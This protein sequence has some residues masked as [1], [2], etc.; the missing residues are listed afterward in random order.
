[1]RRL[2]D[3]HIVVTGASSGIGAEV[4]RLLGKAGARVTLA[5][6]NAERLAAVAGEV[7]SLG[8]Q[9]TCF[10]CD[11]TRRDEIF[12]LAGHAT[13]IF[14]QIDAWI[15]NAGGGI[16][17]RMLEATEEDMLA[18]YRLN[19][20]S[21]LWA[22]QA[23]VPSWIKRGWGQIVDVCSLAGKSGFAFGG[24][25]CA[26]KHAL[27][28]IGDTM[29]QELALMGLGPVPGWGSDPGKLKGIVVTTV[30]PGVT[31][32]DFSKNRVNRATTPE[33]Q[34][35]DAAITR[36]MKS[37]S[38][39]VRMTMGAH[40]TRSVARAIVRALF[41]PVFTL[42]THRGA[43]LVVLAGNLAP[44]LV[45]RTAAKLGRSGRA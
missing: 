29:R 13:N 4:C 24:G 31:V 9:A 34:A 26:S 33:Q 40:S 22:Y 35:E 30:Y 38:R 45:S 23:V 27:S 14:G 7:R 37:G 1:M 43:T 32:S 41:R 19:C 17:H 20:L 12:A 39:L 6:R 3:K 8:G 36:K 42:Y 25:Y 16:Y 21:S 18:Q 44:G 10:T 2:Q 11:V 5:A 15:N 28:A